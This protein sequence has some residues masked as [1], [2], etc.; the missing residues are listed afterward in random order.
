[1]RKPQSVNR[2]IKLC[3]IVTEVAIN[4]RCGVFTLLLWIVFSV[5]TVQAQSALSPGDSFQSAMEF[6]H[7]GTAVTWSNTA[8]AGST[9]PTRTFQTGNGTYCREFQQTITIGGERQQGYGTV[10]RQP[11]GIWQIVNPSSV[12]QTA[13]QVI[14]MTPVYQP[15]PVYSYA[16]PY[17]YWFYPGVVALSFSFSDHHRYGYGR[18]DRHWRPQA[19]SHRSSGHGHRGHRHR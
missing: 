15:V 13:P 7:S 19:R 17:P 3:G 14:R 16:P 4:K 1:M 8:S 6:N 11:D 9:M 12:K 2:S 18:H 5:A 10:C